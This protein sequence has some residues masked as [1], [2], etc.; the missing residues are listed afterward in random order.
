MTRY[1][2][3]NADDFGWT[4][5]INAGVIAAHTSGIVTSAS[6]MVRKGAAA[7]AAALARQ[8]PGLSLGL[9][10]DLGHWSYRH[11]EWIAEHVV[12][13][14]EDEDAVRREVAAQLETFRDLVGRDPT[15]LDGHQHVQR[16]GPARAAVIAASLDLGL[17][18]RLHRGA[19]Y[20]GFFFG[21]TGRGEP[22]H[23]A[24]SVDALV[25]AIAAL[26][27]GWH[28]IGCHPGLYE[29][30]PDVYRLERSMEVAVLCDPA[31]RAGLRELDVGLRSFSDWADG[32][33]ASPTTPTYVP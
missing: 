6:L 20:S 27:E 13:D 26:P 21:Q 15:H 4:G 28:E 1:L 2:I 32:P 22:Y 14:V 19:P 25:S 8:H 24:L 3:V 29:D 23:E 5:G 33:G 18:L 11:G 7:E 12:V 9:H 30:S 31:L 10:I 16:S 17:P